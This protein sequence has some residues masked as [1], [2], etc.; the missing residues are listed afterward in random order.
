MSDI[1]VF[2]VFIV[3]FIVFV[4]LG[5]YGA[6]WRKGDLRLMHEWALAGRNL[7]TILAWFLVGADL[8]TAYT[9]VAVPSSM[10]AKG[11]IYFFAVPYVALTFGIAMIAM[12]TLWKIS[13][14]KKYITAADFAKDKFKSRTVGILVA[15]TG[16]VALL[17]YIA[18]Q[19]VGMQAVLT[20]MLIGNNFLSGFGFTASQTSDL[21]L[22]IAFIILAAFVF[23]SGLRGATLTA[24]MKDILI[25]VTVIVVIIFVPLVTIGNI[26]GFSD[27]FAKAQAANLPVLL[28]NAQLNA[29][30]SLTVLSALALYLYPHAIN[31]A[32]SAES[33]KKL[34]YS[35]ALL[36]IYGIGLALLALFGILIYAV[37]DALKFITTNFTAGTGGIYV[38]PVLIQTVM[39]SWFTGIAFLGIF[40]GGLVP[41]AI[42]A[43]AQA[44]LL[45]RNIV[46]EFRPNMTEHEETRIAKWASVVFKFLALAFVFIVPATYAIQLQLLGGI[47]ILQTLPPIFIGLYSKWFHKNALIVGWCGGM[48]SGIGLEWIANKLAFSLTVPW[49][50]PF[51][52]INITI[53]G[54]V[55]TIAG[56]LY[57]TGSPFGLLF[58]GLI[59]LV[60]NLIICIIL[61]PIFNAITPRQEAKA[62]M[63][64]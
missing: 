8:Y 22:V 17:P 20:V 50:I 5:F 23:T 36:P 38:V 9:F 62:A 2:T 32:L 45:T 46:K 64:D 6:Y 41:A 37:P 31:G 12:P 25:F 24:V 47:L 34:R 14:E 3:L 28:T 49:T 57:N 48:I 55:G 21:A 4:A 39:P 58:I 51:T 19:I 33:S 16:I 1:V 54:I 15:I 56:T 40:I 18:L 52:S 63:A 10:Y 60:V 35:T 7:G 43:M 29:Y 44:N 59:A 13:R 42:M 61:T 11:G 27:A 30:L 26:N 53:P